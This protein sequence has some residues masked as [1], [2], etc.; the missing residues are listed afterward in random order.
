MVAAGFISSESF[1][2]L[3]QNVSN[4]GSSKM[5]SYDFE[6]SDPTNTLRLNY[7]D[8]GS[9]SSV[10]VTGSSSIGFYGEINGSEL[11]WG[12]D[13]YF[14]PSQNRKFLAVTDEN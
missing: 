14:S 9:L 7:G 11:N 12:P 4:H 13:R 10:R 1:H 6:L 3:G 2:V 5:Y 8:T